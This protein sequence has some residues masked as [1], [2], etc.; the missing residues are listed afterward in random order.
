MNLKKALVTG[1]I[2][3]TT[4]LTLGV[5]SLASETGVYGIKMIRE[6]G[7][8]Y[9]HGESIVWRVVKYNNVDM[10]EN[11]SPVKGTGQIDWSKSVYCLKAGVGFGSSTD[12]V[13][14]VEEDRVLYTNEEEL[15]PVA[16]S[17]GVGSSLQTNRLLGAS[18]ESTNHNAMLWVLDHIYAPKHSN[19]EE[20]QMM[21]D[22]L[23][24]A[25]FADK[26]ADGTI[27]NISQVTLTDDEIEMVGQLAIWYFTN[28]EESKYH[29]SSLGTINET[30][31]PEGQIK[32]S[33]TLEE[34]EDANTLYQYLIKT[35]EA[36]APLYA[37]S[38][39]NQDIIIDE[40]ITPKL[41]I[42]NNQ[43]VVG[44]IKIDV[45]GYDASLVTNGAVEC[46]AKAGTEVLDAIEYTIVKS[47]MVSQ[48]TSLEEMNG[49][50]IYIILNS[51]D[52]TEVTLT[53]SAKVQKTKV[54]KLTAGEDE[55]PI[56]VIEKIFDP[57]E[58]QIT[59]QKEKQF[60]LALRKFVT[61][62]NGETLKTSRE[63]KVDVSP[64]VDGSGTTAIYT[65]PKNTIAV[66]NG[67]EVTYTLRI[68]NEG[69]IAGFAK[70]VMD[71][72]PSGLQY[73]ADNSTNQQYGWTM[74]KEENGTLVE[75]QNEEEASII[76]TD[77]LSSAESLIPA[78][79]KETEKLSYQDL[80]IVF[81]VIEPNSSSRVLKNIAEITNDSDES[82]NDVTDRDS[83]P[84][85]VVPSSYPDSTNIEDDDDFEKLVL[86]EFD[87]ALRKF[88]TA[89]NDTEITSREPVVDVSSLKNGSSTTAKYTHPKTPVSVQ[90]GD[91]VTYTI[92][93]YNEG[94][95]SGYAS[96]ITDDIP[97]GLKF[98][99]DDATNIEYMWRL[100][101]DG[102]K[103]TTKYLSMEKDENNLILAYDQETMQSL[104]YKE[105][106]VVFEVIEPNT[107]SNILVNIAEIT[108][109]TDQNG[110]AVI[111]RDSEPN[112]NIDGEDDIDKEYIKLEYFDLA[113]R[114][115]I[116]SV[117]GKAPENSRVPQVN[118]GNLTDTDDTTTTAKYTHPKTP[119]VVQ[120]GYKVVYTIRVYNEGGI[121][122]YVEEITDYLPEGL[123]FIPAE[124]SDINAK[125]EWILSEDEKTVTTDYLS[126]AK[127]NGRNEDCLITGF[128]GQKLDWR[129][130]QIECEVIAEN[131]SENILR[132]IAEITADS[133]KDIDSTPGNVDI[134]NYT[135]P[136]E[137]VDENGNVIPG[138]NSSYQEDDDDYEDLVPQDFDLALRK[139][140]TQIN[141][142]VI[143][144]RYP[145]V[146]MTEEG[147]LVYDH[148]KDPLLV[149]NNDVVI[150]T[151]RVF[152]EG[153][154]AGYASEI[155]DDIPAGLVYLPEHEINQKY[156]WEVSADKKHVSSQYLSKEN[157]EARGEDNLIRAFDKD[158]YVSM[159]EPFNPDYRD[160][161]IAFRVT[162]TNLP[163]SRI[164]INTAEITD[165]QD[166]NGNP[167]T[168]E[169]SEPGNGNPSEDDID[170]EYL[171]VKYFD[172]SLLKW[173]SK[174][175]LTENGETAVTETGHTGLERPEPIVKVDLHRKKINNVTVK[176]GYV[177][178]IT[179][180]GEIEGYASEISDYI[181]E[182]LKFVKEDN[183][184]WE[185]KEGKIVTRALENTLLKPGESATVEVIL[186]WINDAENMGEMVNVAE[187]SEDKNDHGAKDIDSVPNN[188]KDGEDDIDD[189]PVL[190][191]IATGGA[192]IAKYAILSATILA[193]LASGIIAIKKYV[194]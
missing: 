131:T 38:R 154:M 3:L 24:N 81:K 99:I 4:L 27:S 74:Y 19:E 47:D 138:D 114:K 105:V 40:T 119:I 16:I 183:P 143:D 72:V 149:A 150:Y 194:L 90:T 168:D 10:D 185:E 173:V 102:S 79:N 15:L 20:R 128:D 130:V 190:L 120:K 63:P 6:G 140:I 145:E 36:E 189:A 108:D 158:A 97:E 179:N 17:S 191:T 137:S 116:T 7:K 46:V 55:Q 73:I 50:E 49:K 103:I 61:S 41:V 181:P 83:V 56:A 39:S 177:I 48:V 26:I 75:T 100:S 58:A 129:E 62:I 86:K 88:I 95:T 68:Y 175:Y 133:N 186:T 184:A 117:N 82:G 159:E 11:S 66:K 14:L 153:R 52:I 51:K 22:N 113:L 78:F 70:E 77:Y 109:D 169:D 161:Q 69:E 136:Q 104:H 64:L 96:E 176:F 92:R 21:K 192:N 167:V 188:K 25:A 13:P 54:T 187:I 29:V 107:S 132:N 118:I 125:Y 93:I 32:D 157:S 127:S 142:Q 59:I 35:A 84:E 124:E 12:S 110:N 162:E 111:D 28:A 89:V 106:K 37:V 94:L 53:A 101:E 80:Q 9:L 71:T 115:F 171:K 155:T 43:T 122:G 87:L 165:D 5:T 18:L 30:T 8:G 182:G 123:K 147:K 67:D 126:E 141:E 160:V 170:N 164:I 121:D 76:K 57:I 151:I 166:P 2:F 178:Q 135:P 180:E 65:H 174:V 91:K 112:N 139:F 144:T 23:L 1:G 148:A 33:V 98:V 31:D 172:L 60:D 193:I 85:S 152:N 163:S 146:E 156:G 134:D 45:K 42:E 34:Q 44:P